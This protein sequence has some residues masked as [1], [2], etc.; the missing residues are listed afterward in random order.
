MAATLSPRDPEDEAEPPEP[1]RLR[2]LRR[3]VTALT[4]TLTL[5]MIVIASAV[6]WRLFG[7]PPA[8]APAP[9]EAAVLELPEGRVAIASGGMGAELH[10]WT[11]DAEGAERLMIFRR[12]DGALLSDTPI[13]RP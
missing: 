8:P 3:T 13:R 11:R 6:A 5:G 9:L 4:V 12:T 10:V 1:P 2:L 7:A